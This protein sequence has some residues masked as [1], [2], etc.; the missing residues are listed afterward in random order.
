[1]NVSIEEREHFEIPINDVCK[2]LD[3]ICIILQ[4]KFKLVN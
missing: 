1:M 2:W 3:N 4:I